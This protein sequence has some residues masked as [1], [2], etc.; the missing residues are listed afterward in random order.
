MKSEFLFMGSPKNIQE[1]RDTSVCWKSKQKIKINHNEGTDKVIN[2]PGVNV[3][4]VCMLGDHNNNANDNNCDRERNSKDPLQSYCLPSVHLVREKGSE[5]YS[6]WQL[7][8][9]PTK[10]CVRYTGTINLRFVILPHVT[11]FINWHSQVSKLIL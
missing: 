9:E 2:T 7:L 6:E 11:D 8:S 10:S 3:N 4:I 5:C 1:E